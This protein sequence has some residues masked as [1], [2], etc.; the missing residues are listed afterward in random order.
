MTI[1]KGILPHQ[2]ENYKFCAV[3]I[4]DHFKNLLNQFSGAKTLCSIVEAAKSSSIPQMAF[5]DS[6]VWVDIV[7]KD[8]FRSGH[9]G[10]KGRA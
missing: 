5:D 3:S 2:F 7:T 10:D 1:A 4:L 9:A 6:P 8:L